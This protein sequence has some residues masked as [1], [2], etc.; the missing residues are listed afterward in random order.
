LRELGIKVWV[1]DLFRMGGRLKFKG[2]RIVKVHLWRGHQ[3]ARRFFE[4]FYHF[5]AKSEITLFL[6]E[7]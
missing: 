1:R 3:Y 7:G 6:D 5:F 2:G 4:T